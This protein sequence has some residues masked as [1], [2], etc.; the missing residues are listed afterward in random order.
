VTSKPPMTSHG[1]V[2]LRFKDQQEGSQT[3]FCPP[4]GKRAHLD[5]LLN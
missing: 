4:T 5:R 1:V 2:Q 3:S